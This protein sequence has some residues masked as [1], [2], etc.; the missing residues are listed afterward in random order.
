[1][2]PLYPAGASVPL[3][4]PISPAFSTK[5]QEALGKIPPTGKGHLDLSA[6]TSGWQA[7]FGQK[8]GTNS[9]VSAWAGQE[10]TPTGWGSLA[11]GVTAAFNW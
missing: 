9:T 11:A 5:I 1:M 6:A 2:V 8:I 4:Q 10:R 3:P 7:G